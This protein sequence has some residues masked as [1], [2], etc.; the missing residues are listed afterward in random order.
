MYRIQENE[1]KRLQRERERERDKERK[2]ERKKEEY[3]NKT[4]YKHSVFCSAL[5]FCFY[6]KLKQP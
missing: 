1:R 6:I 4:S 3:P 2:K 5:F